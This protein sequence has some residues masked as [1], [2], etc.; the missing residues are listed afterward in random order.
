MLA[1]V[2]GQAAHP[3]AGVDERAQPRV[4]IGHAR[5]PQLLLQL[6][7]LGQVAPVEEV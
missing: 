6:K 5:H 2:P 4:G 3:A 7:G 1:K